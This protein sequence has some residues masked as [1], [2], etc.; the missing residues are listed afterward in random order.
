MR[1]SI[2]VSWMLLNQTKYDDYAQN[3][4][5]SK[6]LRRGRTNKLETETQEML[7]YF[8]RVQNLAN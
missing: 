4:Q 3:V 1:T 8:S 5:K 6:K 7:C 2:L